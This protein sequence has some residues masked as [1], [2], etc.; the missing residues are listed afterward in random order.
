MVALTAN[1][2]IILHIDKVIINKNLHIDII[3]SLPS[4]FNLGLKMIKS[5][6]GDKLPNE[7]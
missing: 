5:M 1:E 3:I 7:R 4:L 2:F 6:P